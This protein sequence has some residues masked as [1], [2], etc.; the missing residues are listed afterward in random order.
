M[1]CTESSVCMSQDMLQSLEEYDIGQMQLRPSISDQLRVGF[2]ESDHASQT[3]LSEVLEL[4]ELTA[5]MQSLVKS[6][7]VLKKDVVFYKNIL[8]AEFEQ[9]IQAQSLK[10]YTRINDSMRDLEAIHNKKLSTLRKS[11]QKQ[12][13][14]ALAVMRTYYENNYTGSTEVEM[15][16]DS[17]QASSAK[18]QALKKKL[19]EKDVL[20]KSLEAQILELEENDHPKQIVFEAEDDPDKKRL[21]EENKEMKEEIEA[22]HDKTQQLQSVLTEKEKYIRI[23]DQDVG[24]MK[25]KMEND[26]KTIEKLSFD[27]ENLR[28]ELEYEKATAAKLLNEEKEKHER[29]MLIRLKEK[30][31]ELNQQKEDMERLMNTK[32]K[33]KEDE[34]ARLQQNHENK[35]QEEGQRQKQQLIYETEYLKKQLQQSKTPVVK[36]ESVSPDKEKLLNQVKML[37]MLKEEQEKDIDRLQRELERVNKTWEKKFEILKQSYHAI[38]D[39]MFLRQSLYRQSLNLHKVS[40]SYMTDDSAAEIPTGVA[41]K[42]SFYFPPLPLPQIGAK[43]SAFHTAHISASHTDSEEKNLFTEDVTLQEVHGQSL[44]PELQVVSDSEG[45]LEGFVPLPPPPPQSS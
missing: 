13:I 8:Q 14:D 30:E 20:I 44:S 21:E 29:M 7:D 11:Y 34:R 38:K 6:V 9:N 17:C 28:M 32:L 12:L 39:E 22:L 2:Y 40:V 42:N 26:Q 27:Q 5:V 18:V 15:A 24:A 36:S 19:N 10:L 41:P 33:E 37:L 43:T 45:D 25:Q 23:L 35:L 16:V 4:K 1:D 3:D 31:L